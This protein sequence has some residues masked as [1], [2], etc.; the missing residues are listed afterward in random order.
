[1]LELT[2]IIF[3]LLLATMC[4][5]LIGMERALRHKPAGLRTNIL[6]GIGST[7]LVIVSLMSGELNGVDPT[8]IASNIVTGIGFLGAGL[9]IHGRDEV[10]G[11]TTA[12]S[13]WVVAAIGMSIGM[14]FIAP[15]LITT[16]LS[17]IVLFGLGNERIRQWLG[18]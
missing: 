6:V 1:M 16:G 7:L 5:G 13:V 8:R 18:F 9:I 3:R 14:G 10:H 15:A 17:L 11:I 4:S 2:D 12:A